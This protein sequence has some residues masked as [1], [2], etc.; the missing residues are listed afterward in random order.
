MNSFS[1]L[2][3]A[4]LCGLLASK[5]ET[6]PLMWMWIGVAGLHVGVYIAYKLKAY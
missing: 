2:T 6:H 3:I 5:A 1:S 4:M